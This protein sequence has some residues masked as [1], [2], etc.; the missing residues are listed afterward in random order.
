MLP[1]SAETLTI[2][3]VGANAAGDDG[4]TAQGGTVT[5]A[6]GKV[7]YTPKANFFGT[8]TFTYT[9]SDGNG[10]TSKA[11]VTVMVNDVNDNPTAN[12][13]QLMALKDFA[14]QELDVLPNDSIAPDVNEVLTIIGLGPANAA[15]AST[16]RTGRPRSRTDGKKIIYTPDPGFET[17]GATST[18][19]PTRSAMAGAARIGRQ[20][21]GGRDR[22]GAQ[23]YLGRGVPGRQ[24]QRDPGSARDRAGR[25]G[26]HADGYERAWCGAES[27]P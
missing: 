8:D 5:I 7:L 10:G 24:Q 16:P 22:R 18:R 13:D 21:P 27:S 15:D 9:I 19:S 6:A 20:R 12:D 4:Q 17:V 1:T 25:S 23:R 26:R 3:S 2:V 14:D 11:T